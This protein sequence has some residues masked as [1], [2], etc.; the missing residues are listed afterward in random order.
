[1][2]WRYEDGGPERRQRVAGTL[3]TGPDRGLEVT[4]RA[5]PAATMVVTDGAGAYFLLRHTAGD[6]AVC[7]VERIDPVTLE[8]LEQSEELPGGP[9]WP[10]GLGVAPDGAIHVVFGDHAHRLDPDLRRTATTRLPRHRPYNS[11]VALA[12]GTLVTKDFAGSRPDRPVAA[13]DREPCELVALDP[14]D[15]R[16][17]DRLVLPEP[18]IARLS[19]QGDTVYVVGDTSLLRVAWDGRRLALDE[20]FRARY[21]TMEGQTYGW[22]CVL[23][24]GAAW[25]L[26]DGEGADGYSGTLRGH[27][28]STAPLHLV[29]VDLT[30]TEVALVEVCGRPG[31]LVANP[32]VVDEERG[33]AVAYDSGNGVLAGFDLDTL[34]PRWRHD[35]DHGGHLLLY[36]G[37][38]ELVTG[39]H[40]DVVVR[41]V[42][43]GA[44]RARADNGT[45]LQSVLFPCPG[46]GGT[47]YV[48]TFLGVS[49]LAVA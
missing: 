49:R 27:G 18:S 10:G 8:P 28:V 32:P 38:G 23:T 40:A 36:E 14:E 12:D 46:D 33:V 29:R 2:T 13:A 42:A 37:S 24:A 6:D 11:F 45:G 22:D 31:G 21:R 41:D 35:Q 17:V 15:L 1:M 47:F 25:F 3:G 43:T 19:A 30:T 16:I 9:V 5:A 26:D 4:T 7:T 20:G 39:D 44:E 48:C 34:E